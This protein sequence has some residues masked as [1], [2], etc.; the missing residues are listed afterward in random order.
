MT[1]LSDAGMMRDLA[2]R[3]AANGYRPIP[4]DVEAKVPLI[5]WKHLYELYNFEAAWRNCADSTGIA[6]ILRGLV[7]VDF[8]A[9]GPEPNGLT[10]YHT[11]EQEYPGILRGAIIEESQSGGRHV[12]HRWTIDLPTEQWLTPVRMG[13]TT[14]NLEVKTGRRLAY[15]YPSKKAGRLAYNLLQGRFDTDPLRQL[16]PLPTLYRYYKPAPAKPACPRI[17]RREMT[18][19]QRNAATEIIIDIYRH[20]A[21]KDGTMH[22]GGLGMAMYMAGLGYD[23]REITHALKAYEAYG[24]RRFRRGELEELVEDGLANPDRDAIAPWKRLGKARYVRS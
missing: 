14:I 19:E 7:C 3:Y 13:D 18:L 22:N 9:H 10:F 12:Y 20:N 23:A 15:C 16:S 17:F 24:H 8:D 1:D 4:A 5:K 2:R 11:I 6:L 21:N